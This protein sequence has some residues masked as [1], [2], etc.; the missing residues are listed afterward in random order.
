MLCNA[1]CHVDTPLI[2]QVF[3]DNNYI[4]GGIKRLI[5]ISCDAVFSGNVTID[6][7][8]TP[9]GS[10][11]DY[12][13]WATLVANRFI[14]ASP[15]GM[16]EKPLPEYTKEDYVSCRPQRVT[17]SDHRVNF[18]S[19]SFTQTTFD[20]CDFWSDLF[21]N[22]GRY[23]VAWQDCAGNIYVRQSTGQPGFQFDF[24]APGHVIPLNNSESQYF[25]MDLLIRHKGIICPIEVPNIDDAFITDVLS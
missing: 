11:D 15:E 18:Q 2:N 24:D 14:V 6:G 7:V 3:C 1:S 10:I 8:S 9:I 12:T 25:Q 19:K 21:D 20:E 22:Y 4:E 16:G 5:F 13:N 23:R 17:V